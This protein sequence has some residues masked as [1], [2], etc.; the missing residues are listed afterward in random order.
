MDPT[1]RN[2]LA[3]TVRSS[4]GGRKKKQQEQ[5]NIMKG[6]F[7]RNHNNSNNKNNNDDDDEEDVDEAIAAAT[8]GD[9]TAATDQDDDALLLEE[10]DRELDQARELLKESM[11]KEN[12]L[13]LRCRHYRQVLDQRAEKL[14]YDGDSKSNNG[15]S[16]TSSAEDQNAS[17]GIETMPSP[18]SSSTSEL[19]DGTKENM[20]VTTDTTAEADRKE[21]IKQLLR[22]EAA[23]EK[24][25]NAHRSILMSCQD[26]RRNIVELEERKSHV[27]SMKKE[28]DVFLEAAADA[29]E[30]ELQ[31]RTFV[32]IPNPMEVEVEMGFELADLSGADKNP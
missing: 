29:D 27:L 12:F 6:N 32:S 18:A 4:S 8:I 17:E 2:A 30:T 20:D 28:C 23:L 24:I 31:Q 10:M 15:A 3:D 19:D 22:D 16:P 14:L 25:V 1:V 13:G 9:V 11:G 26:I 5:R 21:K 7:R